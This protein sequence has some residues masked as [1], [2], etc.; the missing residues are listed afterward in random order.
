VLPL[1][2]A[3][4]VCEA[5]GWE[6]SV[7]RPLREAPAFF[8]LFAAL[9]VIGATAVLIPGVPLLTLLFLPNVVGGILL[10]VILL[11]MLR[12]VNDR[13]IMGTWVNSP[14]QNVIAWLTTGSLIALTIIYLVIAILEGVGVLTG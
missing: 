3:Y 10:P 13:K 11:L 1:S 8:G 5:F 4:A 2:T 12:L 6:R 9:I 14:V 7:N